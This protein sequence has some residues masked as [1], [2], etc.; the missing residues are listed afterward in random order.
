MYYPPLLIL[1]SPGWLEILVIILIILLLF[2][3]KKLPEVMG[4]L[5][6][7]V[8]EFKKGAKEVGRALEEDEEEENDRKPVDEGGEKKNR[9][10]SPGE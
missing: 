1:G 8:K 4:S 6:K 3:A 9:P 5:G 7:G 10:A 2:G